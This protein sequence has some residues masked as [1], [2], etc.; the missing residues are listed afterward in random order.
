MIITRNNIETPTDLIL[1]LIQTDYV[2]VFILHTHLSH[3]QN[4]PVQLCH[5]LT[6]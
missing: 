1:N 2:V 4:N 6:W 3:T 5:S